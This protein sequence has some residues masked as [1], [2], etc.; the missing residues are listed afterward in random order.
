MTAF[1]AF[2]NLLPHDLSDEILVPLTHS[3]YAFAFYFEMYHHDQIKCYT[4][5]CN[6]SIETYADCRPNEADDF[7]DELPF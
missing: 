3:L 4:Q 5:A 7:D 1:D 2:H 6:T